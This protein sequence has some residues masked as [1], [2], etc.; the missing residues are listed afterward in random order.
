[1]G[2]DEFS[3]A[4]SGIS[5]HFECF[6]HFILSFHKSFVPSQHNLRMQHLITLILLCDQSALIKLLINP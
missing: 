2:M 6:P 5:Q 1:M 3:Q 4:T